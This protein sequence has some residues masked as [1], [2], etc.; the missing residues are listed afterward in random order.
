VVIVGKWPA[1]LAKE[2]FDKLVAGE[3]KITSDVRENLRRVPILRGECAGMVTWC[4]I[5][6]KLEGSRMW[7]PVWRVIS[8]P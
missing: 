5:P 6:L 3:F 1:K 2:F 8:Y 7:R 4:W